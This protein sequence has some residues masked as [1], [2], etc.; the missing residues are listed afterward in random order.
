MPSTTSDSGR[1]VT[2]TLVIHKGREMSRYAKNRGTAG[3]KCLSPS[4][5]HPDRQ[6]GCVALGQRFVASVIKVHKL[7]TSLP[8]L[9]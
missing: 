3:E 6:T 5:R 1:K 4:A 7:E 2:H 8:L 9:L